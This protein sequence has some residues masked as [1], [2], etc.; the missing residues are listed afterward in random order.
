[1]AMLNGSKRFVV[2]PAAP[3]QCATPHP[4]YRLKT[5]LVQH[6]HVFLE[7]CDETSV[8]VEKAVNEFNILSKYRYV[9][10]LQY[11]ARKSLRFIPWKDT[12][13]EIAAGDVQ[14]LGTLLG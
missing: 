2:R 11:Q 6:L 10:A 9:N 3:I 8:I 12:G 13:G 5:P 4:L 14:P 7:Y 1:M